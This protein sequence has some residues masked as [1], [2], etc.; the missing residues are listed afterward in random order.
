MFICLGGNVCVCVWKDIK[1]FVHSGFIEDLRM[2]MILKHN[3]LKVVDL[4]RSIKGAPLMNVLDIP[5]HF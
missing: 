5:H 4:H 1:S 3:I 2:H